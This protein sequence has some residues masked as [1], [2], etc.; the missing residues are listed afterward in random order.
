M[1]TRDSLVC[2]KSDV[3]AAEVGGEVVLMSVAQWHYFGL[4]AIGTDIWKRLEQRQSV[5]AL[6]AGL[7]ADYDGEAQAIE[8]DVIELLNKLAARNLLEPSA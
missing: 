6:C 2:R 1:I 5:A 4:N 3:L 8:H 7:A